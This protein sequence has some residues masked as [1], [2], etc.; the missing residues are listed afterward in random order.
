MRKRNHW[1]P[2]IVLLIAGFLA[3]SAWSFQQAARG[4]SAV[5]DSDYYSHGLRY[6]QTR[7][8]QNKALSLGWDMQIAL[9]GRQFKVSLLDSR[10]QPVDGA[11]A[12]L[13][14]PAAP[15]S[16][17]LRLPLSAA[18]GGTYLG[19]IPDAFHGEQTVRIDIERE[20]A[21][22]SRHLLLAIP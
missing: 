1:P 6:D 4:V 9:D 5:T 22:L 2:L 14:L 20:G 7:L 12:E 3:L 17:P 18:T 8:E 19:R 16:V 11:Q 10:R 21:R 15:G 13:T